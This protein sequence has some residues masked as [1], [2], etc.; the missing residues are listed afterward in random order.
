MIY[1][2]SQKTSPFLFFG[3]TQSK[4]SRF[5]QFWCT[6]SQENLRLVGHKLPTSPE[7]CHCEIQDYYCYQLVTEN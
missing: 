2:V 7:K 4:I 3:I 1:T 5:Q 6:E